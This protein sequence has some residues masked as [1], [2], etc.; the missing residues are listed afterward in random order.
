MIHFFLGV[1]GFIL[2]DLV[3]HTDIAGHGYRPGYL[4]ARGH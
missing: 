4:R 1:L 2:M 3:L